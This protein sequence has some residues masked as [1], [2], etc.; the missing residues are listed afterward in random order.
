MRAVSRCMDRMR[1][2]MQT[3]AL[4]GN[5]LKRI[6]IA[7]LAAMLVAP[8]AAAQTTSYDNLVQARMI[9]CAF[10]KG[11]DIDPATGDRI[12]VEG[13]SD[14]LT[15]FQRI[16][17]DHARQITTRLAG[18]REVQIVRTAKYLHYIDS[19]NGMYL[20]T[21]IYACLE[22]DERSGTCLSYGAMQSRQFDPRVLSDPD[23]VYERIR[24]LAEPGFC[25]HSF[26]GLRE[27][28]KP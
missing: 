12:M 27:A 3:F 22:R 1:R 10:Y 21:T 23:S 11:Y 19:I 18:A 2:S 13:R 4:R 17:D 26:I 5:V 28:R 24:D 25:D 15:H 6:R 9:H 20:L 8:A 16:D 7:L 14:T